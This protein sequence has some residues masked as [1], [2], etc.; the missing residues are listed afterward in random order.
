LSEK[1]EELI[2]KILS[3]SLKAAAT[4]YYELAE[5]LVDK[6][7]RNLFERNCDVQAWATFE[8]ILQCCKRFS[9]SQAAEMGAAS[10]DALIKEC[11]VVLEKL[12][13]T[14][15][16]YSDIVM[17]NAA[18]VIIN[19]AKNADLIGKEVSKDSWFKETL[20][21]NVHVSDVRHCPLIDSLTVSYSAPI[22]D[23]NGTVIGVVS[24]RF[25][26]AYGQ[27]M[28]NSFGLLPSERAYFA[29]KDALVIGAT[30]SL[31]V[32]SDH[33]YWLDAGRETAS[34]A[35]GYSIESDR[36]GSPIAVGFARTR[37]YNAYRG[38]KWSAVIVSRIEGQGYE[39]QLFKVEDRAD[40]NAKAISKTD[41][42]IQSEIANEA[43]RGTMTEVESLVTQINKNNREAKFL[44]INASIQS[45]IAGEEGDGFAI[46]AHEIGQLARKSLNF[47]S[48]VNRIS[49]Q[50]HMV[51]Q[52]TITNRI[53]DAAQDAID[54]VDR[55]LFERYCD[56]Q[57]WTT[58]QLFKSAIHKA[59]DRTAACALAANLHKIYEVYHEVILC[60]AQGNVVATAI[61]R[62]LVGKNLGD[63]N[64]FLEAKNGKVN[65]SDV[66]IGK[67]V[68]HPTVTF[69]APICDDSG[70]VIGV[71]ST[72]F[73]CNFLN[74]ILK[75]VI[76]DSKSEVYLVNQDGDLI[77]SE[78]G[79]GVLKR[80]F[81]DLDVYAP[82]HRETRGLV[83]VEKSKFD[84]RSCFYAFAK[85]HGYNTYQ[86][87]QWSILIR[88]PD[89]LH[90]EPNSSTTLPSTKKAA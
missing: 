69:A 31:G 76:R 12:V 16:V 13:D 53:V 49:H 64:W 37:G 32:M 57:A 61:D 33:L 48:V 50:L 78:D 45:G 84:D 25:N 59:E 10:G 74:D 51:V 40:E 18:G 41:K 24:T 26:W 81:S 79:S 72:R 89:E 73:N 70:E 19:S 85:G 8:S 17:V 36:N 23:E 34:G 86:G 15:V 35:C 62:Q 43:L 54:K 46:I 7:D 27:E 5:D 65:Y 3:V 20:A 71:L 80:K 14:Y 39:G 87:K 28:I 82:T 1:L 90:V 22:K 42:R 21:G 88:R 67:T 4:R 77:A 83:K 60:D 52:N 63:R 66:Y 58:F 38:K 56:V 47:V 68:S 9:H 29:N 2:Q 11:Q 6:I 30:A 75:V 55:N 44:A